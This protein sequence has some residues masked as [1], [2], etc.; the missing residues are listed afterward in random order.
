MVDNTVFL[1]HKFIMLA[2]VVH[3]RIHLETIL[4]Q[5]HTLEK[6][7]KVAAVKLVLQWIILQQL[8]RM[9]LQIVVAVLVVDLIIKVVLS[10]P[11]VVQASWL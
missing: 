2:V 8:A 4:M 6:V 10:H 5:L 7:D 1:V 3:L 11:L 9:E